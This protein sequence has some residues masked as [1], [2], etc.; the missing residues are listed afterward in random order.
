MRNTTVMHTNLMTILSN[1]LFI[2][3]SFIF[4]DVAVDINLV[5]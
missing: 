5:S 3:E 1:S 4:A 2:K